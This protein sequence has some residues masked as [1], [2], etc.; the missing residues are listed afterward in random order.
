M[1]GITQNESVLAIEDYVVFTGLLAF[2]TCI[3]LF[4][5]YFDSKKDDED[6]DDESAYLVGNRSLS[7]WPVALSLTA[8]FMSSITVI[9]TPAE[10]YYYGT[11]F[12]WFLL[13][14]ILV[15]FIVNY[16]YMPFFYRQGYTSTYQYI[17]DRFGRSFKLLLCVIYTFNTIV[18]AGIVIYA[19]ALAIREVCKVNMDA[20]ILTMGLVCCVYTSLGGIKAVIWTDVVQYLAM[21]AGFMVIIGKGLLDMGLDHIIETAKEND[22]W[23]FDDFSFDPRVRHSVWSCVVGGTLGLWL[24]VY[25]VNQSNVQRYVSC[26]TVK[27]AS[28]AV[29][30]NCF[31]LMLINFTAASSGLVMFAYY[32]GCD[33]MQAGWIKAKDQ[34]VP[35][36]VLDKLQ[37][38]RGL[39]GLFLASACSGTL[40]TVSS[41]INSVCAILIE[42]LKSRS[43]VCRENPYFSSRMVVFVSGIAATIVA[44]VA[45]S[46][47]GT[48]LQASM[49][50]NGIVAGPTLGLFTLGMLA[51]WVGS[52]S[53]GLGF[54]LG[55][56]TGVI[57]YVFNDPTDEFTRKLPVNTSQCSANSTIS[58]EQNMFIDEPEHESKFEISYIYLSTAGL[59]VT[60]IISNLAS[61]IFG[62]PSPQQTRKSLYS[63]LIWSIPFFS[64]KLTPDNEKE[65][66]HDFKRSIVKSIEKEKL[67]LTEN[68][69][70]L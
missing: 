67:L 2:S 13:S 40:S 50:I 26:R 4:F 43:T 14:Y 25:G 57:L 36:M 63:S 58:T 21:Y 5:A 68:D 46:I 61:F 16:L 9:S 60:L 34:L 10:I 62:P 56:F 24:G 45:K 29:W 1:D 28:K 64:S 37:Q 23:K 39:P 59:L 11:M 48:V 15:S 33:P 19:P 35:Y 55:L 32:N 3:G 18:Y 69:F 12:L 22:R 47:S 38:Y 31:A 49:S 20:A 7:A 52:K 6:Y 42:E 66:P 54:S 70:K 17:E 53:A 44:F 27:E 41:G 8:S 51:P 30:I 65:E